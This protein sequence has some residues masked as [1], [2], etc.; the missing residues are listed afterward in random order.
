[1]VDSTSTLPENAAPAVNAGDEG[2]TAAFAKMLASERT[3]PEPP[4][5]PSREAE[6]DTTDELPTEVSPDDPGSEPED[7]A[8]TQDDPADNQ[9]QTFT[10]R[11]AGEEVTVPLTELLAGY[12][13]QSDYTRKT[14]ALAEK[15]TA[16]ESVSRDY[17]AQAKALEGVRAEYQE[18][19][20]RLDEALRESQGEPDWDALQAADPIEFATQY[21]RWQVKQQ[22]RQAV[23]EELQRTRAAA[24]ESQTAAKARLVER[25]TQKLL[26]A[27]PDWK[28]EAK[29]RT[30]GA[31][32]KSYAATLG[33]TTEDLAPAQQD[34]RLVRLL[35]DA[36]R[37]HELAAK[38]KQAPTPATTKT[39]A[40]A[41]QA[42]ARKP[43]ARPPTSELTR[44]KQRLAKTHAADDAAPIFLA[45][46]NAEAAAK[47]R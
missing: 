14:K 19:L 18:R 5:S 35:H 28:D 42:A 31:R 32:I 6:P 22:R 44:A 21:A 39:A 24:E 34:H 36:A 10:F 46:L 8:E 12:T 45:L 20:S 27:I 38:V 1:M 13:R 11:S 16:L 37:Y 15:Q 29:A 4:A 23:Q 40:T 43:G 17:E 3:P 7:A 47:G 41:Q 9:E 33:F 2:A 25:E 30:D 26:E